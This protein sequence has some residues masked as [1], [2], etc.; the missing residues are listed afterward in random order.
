[1]E[2][3]SRAHHLNASPH[4]TV[5]VTATAHLQNAYTG[6]AESISARHSGDTDIDRAP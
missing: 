5:T 2:P 6:A 4:G 1:M 3:C